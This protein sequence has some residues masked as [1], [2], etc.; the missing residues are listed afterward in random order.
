MYE[1]YCPYARSQLNHIRQEVKLVR[2]I[3]LSIV[4]ELLKNNIAYKY[5][6]K[7]QSDV[8]PHVHGAIQL[9]KSNYC[10]IKNIM[11]FRKCT[12]EI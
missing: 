11:E 6:M 12:I 10:L 4:K 3:R 8:Q 5:H 9:I 7:F 2:Q 1:R